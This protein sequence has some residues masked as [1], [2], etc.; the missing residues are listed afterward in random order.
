MSKFSDKAEK[1]Y[2]EQFE[3]MFKSEDKRQKDHKALVNKFAKSSAG[4]VE[5]FEDVLA[6]IHNAT[7]KGIGAGKKKKRSK[8]QQFNEGDYG[9]DFGGDEEEDKEYDDPDDMP[10]GDDEED[11]MDEENMD[12]MDVADE[13]LED[14]DLDA[15]NRSAKLEV[16]RAIIDSAQNVEDDEGDE[17][18]MSFDDFMEEMQAVIEE[19]DYDDEGEGAEDFDDEGDEDDL[20]F[21]DDG[22]DDDFGGEEEEEEEVIEESVKVKK[23]KNVLY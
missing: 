12:E 17:E 19:F 14:I 20:E 23:R 6:P 9:F 16:I 21:E 22:E 2:L 4:D 3:G 11:G 18:A 7:I 15:V 13:I 5:L 1:F 10:I 8:Q